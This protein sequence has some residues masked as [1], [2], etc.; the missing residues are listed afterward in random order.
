MRKANKYLYDKESVLIPRKGSLN[1]I[2]YVNSPFWTVDTMFY[3]VMKQPNVA[4]YVHQFMLLQNLGAMNTGS[5]VPSMTT[6]V[7]NNL[8]IV[9]PNSSVLESFDK[10]ASSLYN[11]ISVNTKQNERLAL[12][13]DTLLPKLMSGEIRV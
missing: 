13:R 12:L 11:M 1:N 7:L 3:T 2:M 8:K 4:K 6:D 9:I 5:A 10:V